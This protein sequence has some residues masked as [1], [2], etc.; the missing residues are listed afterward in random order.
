MNLEDFVKKSKKIHGNNFDYSKFEYTG[1]HNRSLLICNI[2]RNEFLSTPSNN[3]IGSGCKKCSDRKRG[4]YKIQ[5]KLRIKYPRWEFKFGD[6]ENADSKIE[7]TCSE[8]HKGISNYRNIIRYNVCGE[9]KKLKYLKN[10]IQKIK[11][12]QLE[13]LNYQNDLKIECKCLK[14]GTSIIGNLDKFLYKNFKCKYCEL[15]DKSNLL[16]N[17]KIKLIK[18]GLDGESQI[19]NLECERGHIYN[20][21][22]RN[23]LSERGCNICRKENI[24]PPKDELFRLIR[25]IHGNLYTYDEESYISIRNKIS[26]ICRKGHHFKQKVSNHL[27]GKGCPICRES[28]GE[29]VISKYLENKKVEFIRQKKFTNCKNIYQMPFDFYIPSINTCIEYDGIQHFQAVSLF[30]GEEELKKLKI[31]DSKK[32]AYCKNNNINLVR[33]SYKDNIEEKLNDIFSV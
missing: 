12:N 18:I 25:S 6:Y 26:I 1:S 7:Y 2:C 20:Q 22:R 15:L 16:R 31:R 4:F 30:G 5:E 29:R 14:C 33:I 28:F 10:K 24:S 13:I 8:N 3:L 11:N 32:N 19:L 23:L 27:Q 21:D 9:C 17:G